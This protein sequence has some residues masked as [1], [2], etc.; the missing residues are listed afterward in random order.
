M[1][2]DTHSDTGY[3]SI[4]EAA[5]L[6]QV[7]KLL[8]K[9]WSLGYSAGWRGKGITD[10]YPSVI[11]PQHKQDDE[12]PLGFFNIIELRFLFAFRDMF[13]LQMLRKFYTKA[14]ELLKVEYPFACQRFYTDGKKNILAELVEYVVDELGK[15][16]KHKVLV[17]LLDGQMCWDEILKPYLF[18]GL[19][20]KNEI[21]VRWH[22]MPEEAPRVIIDPAVC[23]GSPSLLESKIATKV[24][25]DTYMR[26]GSIDATIWWHSCTEEEVKQAI[27]YEKH[28]N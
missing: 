25:Y 19:E 2:N 28:L 23:F 3:Y 20:Y 24:L 14:Q 18:L 7:S 8:V 15:V 13:S 27:R 9:N 11:T 22:P 17:D 16:K 6:L 10:K 21:V 5:R 26:E 12:F 1:Q 4:R